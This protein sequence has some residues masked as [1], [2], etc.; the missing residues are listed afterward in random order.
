MKNDYIRV[1]FFV[2]L[3]IF[4]T[5]AGCVS[6]SPASSRE[7]QGTLNING[8]AV[9]SPVMAKEAV[10][11]NAAHPKAD[12][13]S[14]QSSSGAG[15]RDLSL[16]SIDIAT[17]SQLPKQTEYSLAQSNGK[18]LY[19][20]VI[21]Y[22][23]L[24]V[25]VNPANPVND[26]SK[27]QLK[28]IFFTGTINDWSQVSNGKKSGKIHVYGADPALFGTASFFN[29]VISENGSTPYVKGY[30]KIGSA[31]D[32]QNQ[33]IND[34]DG[35]TYTSNNLITSQ[36]KVLSINGFLPSQATVLDTTYPISRQLFVVTDGA[37]SGLAK[38]FINFLMSSKGQ[39]I[40]SDEGLFP[41]V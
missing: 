38:E 37:P 40:I 36:V 5:A 33:V 19:L 17:T 11:F 10:A 39:Q 8:S 27:D 34:P 20:T 16:G 25:V 4:L 15:I 2:I 21:A 23:A 24:N 41:I 32:L 14:G 1:K 9:M 28:E 7:I 22:D 26:L 31:L 3:L 13:I 35:I 30:N 18:T 29:Q 6:N 12:I